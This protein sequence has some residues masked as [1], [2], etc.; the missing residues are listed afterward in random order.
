M[1]HPLPF[2]ADRPAVVG[3]VHLA[4]LP[5][6]PAHTLAMEAILERARLDASL[7][8]RAG[9]DGLLVENY[10]DTPFHP[11]EVPAETIA[12]LALAVATVRNAV[13]GSGHDAG[14]E[15]PVGVNV[16]RNDARAALG[17]AAVTGARFVRVNVHAGT[18]ATDQG[19]LTG[20]AHQTLRIRRAL[21]IQCPILADVH[22]KHATPPPGQTVGAAA[23]DLWERAG[24]DGLVVSGAATGRATD[25]AQ[26]ARV[27]E[28]VPP[29]PIWIG[30]G[31]T[32]ESVPALVRAGASGFIVGSWVQ[33]DGQAG[34]G[35]DEGRARR[36]VAA[37]RESSGG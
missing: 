33:H 9:C 37:V 23:R 10:G 11:T 35:V 5:G 25:P 6:A 27:R 4:A 31:S 18:M 34:A 22:V 26:V 7:L 12:A 16:L 32:P 21:G 30:S 36:F 1:R 28:A 19:V 3:M 17:I 29:A 2:P 20:A 8:A 15:L 13:R 14:R 24:A